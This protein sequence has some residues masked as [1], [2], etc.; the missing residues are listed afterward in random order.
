MSNSEKWVL[1]EKKESHASPL[2]KWVALAK[3]DHTQK[4][5]S[6]LEKL[7]TFGKVG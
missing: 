7:V 6:H 2:E 1:F 3:V 5:G 4:S